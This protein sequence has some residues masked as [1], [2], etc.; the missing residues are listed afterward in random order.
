MNLN[1]EKLLEEIDLQRS[2]LLSTR[3]AFPYMSKAP[4]GKSNFETAPFYEWKG[5]GRDIKLREPL[6][7]D[8]LNKIR[9]IGAWINQNYVIRLHAILEAHEVIPKEGKGNIDQN[10]DNWYD[11]DLVRRLRNQY[12]HSSGYYDPDENEERKLYENIVEYY[13]VAEAKPPDKATDYPLSIDKVL[14]PMTAAC[15][16]YIIQ[17]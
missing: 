10:L 13:N 16:N 6:T 11:V 15:E 4:I 8:K 14:I 5:Y 1:K 12:A 17:L 9:A 2:Y 7:E 3:S